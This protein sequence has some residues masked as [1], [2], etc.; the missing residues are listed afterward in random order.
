MNDPQVR[1]LSRD[2]ARAL[3]REMTARTLSSD[4]G[5]KAL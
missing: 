5:Y 2:N 3:F 4:A 1:P